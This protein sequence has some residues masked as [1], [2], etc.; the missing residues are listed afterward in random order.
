MSE[1][2]KEVLRCKISLRKGTKTGWE[3]KIDDSSKECQSTLGE[4]GGKMG[5]HGRKY[6]KK[7]I[8]TSSPE[9][10]KTLKDSGLYN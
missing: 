5:P 6:L 10:K 4:I 3:L 7:R 2:K 8:E 9:V 1:K